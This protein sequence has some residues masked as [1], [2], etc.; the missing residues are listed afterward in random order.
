M[1]EIVYSDR[2]LQDLDRLTDFLLDADPAS[3]PKTAALITEAV[4]VLANHPFIGRAA[5]EG[6][7]ELLIS[8]GHS[9]YVALYNYEEPDDAVLI[10]SIRPQ[11]EAGYLD[12]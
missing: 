8:R 11:R 6:M 10:L 5:E 2:A 3:A 7:R 4:Q 9:G 1:A 12:S